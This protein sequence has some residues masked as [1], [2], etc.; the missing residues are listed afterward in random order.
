MAILRLA[1][2]TFRLDE[3]RR[4]VGETICKLDELP[5]G[6]VL[7]RELS[8]LETQP[9]DCPILEARAACCDE[10]RQECGLPVVRNSAHPVPVKEPLRHADWLASYANALDK[11][12]DAAGA[13]LQCSLRELESASIGA[14]PS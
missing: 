7:G 12:R 8:A 2:S 10:L 14:Q 11:Y 1:W 3:I 4:V 13:E 6:R 5:P 9:E